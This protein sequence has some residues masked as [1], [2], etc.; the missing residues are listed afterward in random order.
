MLRL[1][2]IASRN[3]ERPAPQI[4][5]SLQGSADCSSTRTMTPRCS[6]TAK[7]LATLQKSGFFHAMVTSSNE[8]A[9]K[10]VS[11]VTSPTLSHVVL[12]HLS[13]CCNSPSQAMPTMSSS[14]IPQ[15]H[16]TAKIHCPTSI[17]KE[18]PFSVILNQKTCN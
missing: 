11:S 9:A 14:L 2:L 1:V 12:G 3:E 5:S 16:R 10:V 7:I 18:F 15:I 4:I 6:A 13:E 8:E 17:G